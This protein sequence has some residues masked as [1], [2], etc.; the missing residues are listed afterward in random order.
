LSIFPSARPNL[1]QHAAIEVILELEN[2]LP[3]LNITAGPWP[4][5]AHIAQ[6]PIINFLIVPG[7]LGQPTDMT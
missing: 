5:S 6:W 4:F 1:H 7:H 3:E 2:G